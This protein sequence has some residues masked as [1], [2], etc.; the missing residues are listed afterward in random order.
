MKGQIVVIAHV[1]FLSLLVSGFSVPRSAPGSLSPDPGFA[2]VELFTSEGCSSCPPA[3][4][5]VSRLDKKQNIY[6]LSFHVDYWKDC[7]SDPAYSERQKQY[8]DIFHLSSIY[9]PQIIINGKT[10]MVGSDE[11]NLRKTIDEY[12]KEKPAYTISLQLQPIKNNKVFIRGLTNA[13]SESQFNLALVQNRT[14]SHIQRGENQG[15]TLNHFHIVRAFHMISIQNGMISD[16]LIMPAGL[17]AD[18]CILIAYL[19]DKTTGHIEAV[20]SSEIH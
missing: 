17:S 10:E 12:I 4:E 1:F 14:S 5:I 20:T 13:N 19:Q 15:K 6:V 2:V 18:D 11:N 16:E 8:G 3:D 9:T 7:F